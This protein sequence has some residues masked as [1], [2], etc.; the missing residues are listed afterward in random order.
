MRGKILEFRILA[1]YL[2]GVENVQHFYVSP[3]VT[4]LDPIP[5]PGPG[6]I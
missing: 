4:E 1:L 3:I 6:L 2:H 5:L